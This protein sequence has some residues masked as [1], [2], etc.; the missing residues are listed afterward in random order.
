MSLKDLR[1]E[2]SII[3]QYGFL[4]NSSMK[5]NLDPSNSISRKEMNSILNKY[6]S[7]KIFNQNNNIDQS[8][9][10]ISNSTN[11]DIKIKLNQNNQNEQELTKLESENNLFIQNCIVEKQD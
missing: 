10:E 7:L 4:F 2:I 5:D 6:D 3:P 8:P 1:K 11:G 9:L